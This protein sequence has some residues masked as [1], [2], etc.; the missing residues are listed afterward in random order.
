MRKRGRKRIKRLMMMTVV[1]RMR[2]RMAPPPKPEPSRRGD[3]PGRDLA[4]PDL[5]ELGGRGG[6]GVQVAAVQT[7]F[8]GA[9]VAPVAAVLCFWCGRGAGGD[10]VGGGCGDEFVGGCWGGCWTR[11][12]SLLLSSLFSGMGLW[13][14]LLGV[15]DRV[16]D[17]PWAFSDG[18]V[19]MVSHPVGGVRS[20]WG[21]RRRGS[22]YVRRRERGHR[23]R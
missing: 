22:G 23:S 16:A 21:G 17:P 8:A 12:L 9:V 4:Q 6:H 14:W 3:P 11:G 1:M 15:V 7:P 19:P 5:G 13:L 10:G 18:V 2:M 20:R